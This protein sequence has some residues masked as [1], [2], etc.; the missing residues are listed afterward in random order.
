MDT[1]LLAARVGLSLAAVLGL[2]WWLS[3]RMQ[4]T[5]LLRRRHRETLTV[6]GRQQLGGK[7]GVALIEASGRR[8]VVGYGEQGVTLLHDAGEAPEPD[9]APDGRRTDAT[10]D[11]VDLDS[12]LTSLTASDAQDASAVSRA[13]MAVHAP[14]RSMSA[15]MADARRPRTPLEGSILA[16]DT[17][18]KAVVAVQ[19][20]TTRRS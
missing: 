6:L 2:M 18:R 14:A 10:H 3:R 5:T 4:S 12:E 16:P 19:E 9:D 11:V 7:T 1:L 20:R 17:W 15:R 13:A 8:L